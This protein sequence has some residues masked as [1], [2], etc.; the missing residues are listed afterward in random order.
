MLEVGGSKPSP[1]TTV[2]PAAGCRDNLKVSI[3]SCRD[4]PD[5]LVSA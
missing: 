5:N 1:P 4:G 3:A 2:M